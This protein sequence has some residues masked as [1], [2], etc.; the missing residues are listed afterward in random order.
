M[1]TRPRIDIGQLWCEH[2][3][4]GS[5]HR[6]KRHAR[7][8]DGPSAQATHVNLSCWETLRRRCV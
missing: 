7:K 4:C 2:L 1:V 6:L 8:L 5:R 3:R